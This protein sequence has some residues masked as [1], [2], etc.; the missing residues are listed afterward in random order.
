MSVTHPSQLADTSCGLRNLK[1][2]NILL[3]RPIYRQLRQDSAKSRR[4]RAVIWLEILGLLA[5][6][7]PI[8]VWLA[9]LM[10]SVDSLSMGLSEVF[11][12]QLIDTL[13]VVV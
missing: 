7:P 5:L 12:E 2:G 3:R 6:E 10:I 11:R 9:S 1:L 4:V 13:T 8:H